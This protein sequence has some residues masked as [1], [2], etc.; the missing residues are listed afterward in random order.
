M[1]ESWILRDEPGVPYQVS[2][3]TY[4]LL[5]WIFVSEARYLLNLYRHHA[6]YRESRCSLKL[7]YTRFI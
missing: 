3:I 6:A 5:K 4:R 7:Q 1:M 2:C